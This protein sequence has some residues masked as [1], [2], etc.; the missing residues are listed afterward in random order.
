MGSTLLL[1]SFPYPITT[2]QVPISLPIIYIQWHPSNISGVQ[3]VTLSKKIN[4]SS[5]TTQIADSRSWNNASC[6]LIFL[7][8]YTSIWFLPCQSQNPICLISFYCTLISIIPPLINFSSNINY[9][10]PGINLWT[11]LQCPQNEYIVAANG[12]QIPCSTPGSISQALCKVVKSLAVRQTF[13][14]SS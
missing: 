13:D 5:S 12:D 1:S 6:F 7:L 10:I 4:L 11:T 2:V 14:M 3:R 8:R 9:F